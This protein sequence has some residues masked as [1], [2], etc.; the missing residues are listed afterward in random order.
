MVGPIRVR[1][2]FFERA[3]LPG[4]PYGV[5]GGILVSLPR[6]YNEVSGMQGAESVF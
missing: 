3:E 1:S 4:I 5:E 6:R 2:S